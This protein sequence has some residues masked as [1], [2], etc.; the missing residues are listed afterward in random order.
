MLI[1]YDAQDGSLLWDVQE[2]R[3]VLVNCRAVEV[4]DYSRAVRWVRERGW[5]ELP[6]TCD[7]YAC[8]ASRTASN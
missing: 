7:C 1:I 8:R 4:L 3:G 2:Q 6:L 5:S